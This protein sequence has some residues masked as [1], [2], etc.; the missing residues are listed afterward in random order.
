VIIASIAGIVIIGWTGWGMAASPYLQYW[1][2]VTGMLVAVMRASS[3]GTAGE[4]M[5]RE[6]VTRKNDEH[7]GL[8]RR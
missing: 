2:M 7:V 1:F 5:T 8:R 4:L 3:E 6:V